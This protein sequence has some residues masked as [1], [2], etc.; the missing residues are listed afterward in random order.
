M[1]LSH[2]TTLDSQSLCLLLQTAGCVLA[3]EDC[4]REAIFEPSRNQR[5]RLDLKSFRLR[6][7]KAASEGQVAE[8]A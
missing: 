5:H 3:P 7:R 4:N 1:T 6:Y 8:S 2:P